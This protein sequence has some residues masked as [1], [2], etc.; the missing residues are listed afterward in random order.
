MRLPARFGRTAPEVQRGARHQPHARRGR[1]RHGLGG[2]PLHIL[3]ALVL[4]V[5]LF[6]PMAQIA[7]AAPVP[8]ADRFLERAQPLPNTPPPFPAPTQVVAIGNFQGALGCGDYD[9]NCGATQLTENRGIWSG[10]FPI[11]PGSYSF[12]IAA[13]S[14]QVRSL[15]QNADPNGGDLSLDVPGDATGV[16]FEYNPRTGEIIAEPYAARVTL[17]GDFGTIDM[18]PSGGGFEAFVS[19]QPGAYNFQVVVD[20]QP[21]GEPQQISVDTATRVQFQVDS[22]GNLVGQEQV[23]QAGLTVTKTDESGAPLQGSCFSLYDGG[24]LGTQ[25]CDADDGED[26]STFLLF[27]NG[28]NPGTYELVETFTPD[29]QPQADSQDVEINTG[30]FDS[31]TVTVGDGGDDTGDDSDQ[32]D[33][34]DEEETPADDGQDEPPVDTGATIVVL[35]VDANDQ[36]LLL[37]G[38]CYEV[39]GGSETCD[40]DDGS[41]DGQT[42]LSVEPGSVEVTETEP[43]DGYQSAGTFSLD[44]FDGGQFA[45]PHSPGQSDDGDQGD[46]EPTEEPTEDVQDTGLGSLTIESRDENGNLIPGGCYA[47]ANDIGPYGPKCDD[48]GDGEVDY[49]DLGPG[50]QTITETEPAP[51]YD[52]A[53]DTEQSVDVGADES[54]TITFEYASAGQGDETPPSDDIEEPEDE[55]TPEG[56]EE[57][58]PGTLTIQAQDE[59]GNPLGGGCYSVENDSGTYGPFCDQEDDGVVQLTE[60]FPGKTPSPR[61]RPRRARARSTMTPSRSM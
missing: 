10:S 40:E 55:E 14:D 15:G 47:G 27:Q 4:L 13:L 9:P 57:G 50:E 21:V 32:I 38:A 44:A 34:P 43:P 6:G 59:S 51:G 42:T 11:P 48:D 39:D 19:L 54:E 17:S 58:G 24:D 16:Y 20:D 36:N 61:I 3:G 26:G 45:L 5:N 53:A 56:D 23:D 7:A 41:N 31:L 8:L 28:V 25:A 49:T 46:E 2:L 35:A 12:R 1:R 30:S 37:P 29:G 22:S 33:E 60:V 52:E 18:R